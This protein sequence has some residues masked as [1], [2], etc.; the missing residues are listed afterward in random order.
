[1]SVGQRRSVSEELSAE[2][3]TE[4]EGGENR[5]LVFEDRLSED[6]ELE[7]TLYRVDHVG[8]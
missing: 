1:M 4:L 6:L 3:K 8:H 2:N 7:V 5:S